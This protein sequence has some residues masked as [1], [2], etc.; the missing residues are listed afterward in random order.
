MP[1]IAAILI[2]ALLYWL[3]PFILALAI[4]ATLYFFYQSERKRKI[5]D[6]REN[7][8]KLNLAK[9]TESISDLK[10]KYVGIFGAQKVDNFRI[11][12][13][14]DIQIEQRLGKKCLSVFIMRVTPDGGIS[15]GEYQ[16]G[17]N[18]CLKFD[19]QVF[20]ILEIDGE[21]DSDAY[22]LSWLLEAIS[23]RLSNT[24]SIDLYDEVSVEAQ[25]SELLFLTSPEVQWASSAINKIENALS[26]VAAAYS[27]S[28]SNELLKGNQEY[29]LRAMKV[30][31]K[32]L[33]ELKTYTQECLD[34]MRKAYEFLSIPLALRSFDNLDTKPLEIYSRKKEMRQSFQSAIDVKREYD[35]LR[36]V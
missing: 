9:V 1:I 2:I 3:W 31:Q 10:S 23:V 26:P 24:L 27:V 7:C 18:V 19:Q 13:I 34:A 8:T 15:G 6:A 32:E 29:L 11:I 12:K 35:D 14:I 25:L 17:A 33:N 36:M 16:L 28:L 4:V 21:N 30:M 5:D 22:S 20:K